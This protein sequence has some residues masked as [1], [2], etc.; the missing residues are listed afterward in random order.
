MRTHGI[1]SRW[2]DERGFGFITLPHSGEEIF[3]HIYSFPKNGLRPRIGELISFEIKITPDGKKSA[4]DVSRPGGLNASGTKI[5]IS[6]SRK[7]KLVSL[8]FTII[9]IGTVIAYGVNS[10]NSRH[11]HITDTSTS[12]PIIQNQPAAVVENKFKCDGRT[13]CSQMTSC[14]EAEYF[15]QH[16]T[17]TVMDGD[18]DGE[19][20]EQQWCN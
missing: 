17:N 19:P 8:I 10:Y 1:L 9:I 5:R 12:P 6:V 18:H 14:E 20:C 3:V 2:N 13:H 4:L 15:L 7:I 16:C 11:N